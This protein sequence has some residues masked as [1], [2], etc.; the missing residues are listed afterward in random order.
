MALET[1]ARIFVLSDRLSMAAQ[2]LGALHQNWKT[3]GLPQLG[4]PWMTDEHN[5]CMRDCRQ[6]LG[7]L[8]YKNAFEEGARL[9]LDEASALAL[10]DPDAPD[11]S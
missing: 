6:R 2:L 3:A 4:A 8:A 5:S 10:D 1:A 7:E 9:D 11:E